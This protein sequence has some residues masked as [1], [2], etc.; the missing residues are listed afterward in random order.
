[1][2]LDTESEEIIKQLT[3]F[4]REIKRMDL[5]VHEFISDREK[6]RNPY[7]EGLAEKIRKYEKQVYRNPSNEVKL[8]LDNLLNSL[9]T[10]ERSWKQLFQADAE[11]HRNRQGR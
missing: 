9:L 4:K 3:E 5:K 2:A 8:H 7:S 10:Y 6:Y 1:M 11:R